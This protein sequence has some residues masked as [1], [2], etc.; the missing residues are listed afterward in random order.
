MRLVIFYPGGVSYGCLPDDATDE[1]ISE[2]LN[3]A[4]EEEQGNGKGI[5]KR[6]PT[7]GEC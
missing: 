7:Y 2:V 4:A 6:R 5:I 3:I 1:E